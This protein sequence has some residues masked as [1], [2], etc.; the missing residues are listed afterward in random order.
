MGPATNGSGE[1]GMGAKAAPSA[2]SPGQILCSLNAFGA[3]SKLFL[4]KRKCPPLSSK[5]V[6]AYHC[7][8][9]GPFHAK[10]C[11]SNSSSVILFH[12]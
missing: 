6:L 9:F 2:G 1:T 3:K 12:V 10:N 7:L 11:H 8:M 5:V 4:E